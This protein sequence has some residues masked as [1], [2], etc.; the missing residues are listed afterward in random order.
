MSDETK[1]EEKPTEKPATPEVKAPE[2]GEPGW[3]KPRLEQAERSAQSALL[4]RLG[5]DKAEDVEA[6]LKRLDELEKSQ[7]SER[8]IAQKERDALLAQANDAKRYSEVLTGRRDR[9]FAG[10]TD[11]QRDAVT[12]VAGDDPVAQLKAID[13]LSKTWSRK[14][15]EQKPAGDDEKPKPKD[16][17]PPKDAP[18][19]DG[20]NT[21]P[22]NHKEH[23]QKLKT[24]NPVLAGLYLNDH[25]TE[26]YPS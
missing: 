5:V 7:L 16:T 1:G 25:L 12:A 2:Q 23:Y 26:I 19:G 9:E 20:G 13:A 8:E 10:L 22:V 4:K 3:L 17:A 21:S 18:R 6:R 24:T 11:A 14:P 15:E